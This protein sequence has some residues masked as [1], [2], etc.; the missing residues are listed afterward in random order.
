MSTMRLSLILAAQQMCVF[1]VLAVIARTGFSDDNDKKLESPQQAAVRTLIQESDIETDPEMAALLRT[2]DYGTPLVAPTGLRTLI[3]KANVIPNRTHLTL[4]VQ[5]KMYQLMWSGELAVG[6]EIDAAERLCTDVLEKLDFKPAAEPSPIEAVTSRLRLMRSSLKSILH[7]QK[8]HPESRETVL[9]GVYEAAALPNSK[10][11]IRFDWLVSTGA[12]DEPLTLQAVIDMLPSLSPPG[13]EKE[14]MAQFA[15]L[16]I[17]MFQVN[18]GGWSLNSPNDIRADLAVSLKA[19][20]YAEDPTFGNA[21]QPRTMWIHNTNGASVGV[22]PLTG[23][24]KPLFMYV[25]R[26][27]V[28]VKVAPELPRI[29]PRPVKSPR[30]QRQ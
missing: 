20:E 29:P 13:M 16:P 17:E 30:E 8:T 15:K 26:T 10:L 25:G 12:P 22:A 28:T 19:E 9:I 11:A 4:R 6:G 23:S 24:D 3:T 14:L 1:L 18:P 7:Y 27:S 2:N 5:Q 21:A